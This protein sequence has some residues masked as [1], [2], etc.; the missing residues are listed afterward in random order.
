MSPLSRSHL[1][2]ALLAGAVLAL[3]PACLKP[4]P[5]IPFD[6]GRGYMVL[7]TASQR[8]LNDRY[9]HGYVPY[10][11]EVVSMTPGSAGWGWEFSAHLADDTGEDKER[12]VFRPTFQPSGQRVKFNVSV[13]TERDTE[14]YEVSAGVRQA[15]FLD[16]RIQPYFGVGTSVFYL[17]ERD[18]LEGTFVLTNPNNPAE[19]ATV[20]AVDESEREWNFGVYMR[21]GLAWR[22][23]GDQEG[24]RLGT[25]FTTDLRGM[26]GTYFSSVE[27]VFGF[28]FGR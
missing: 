20:T 6:H 9:V 24:K 1:S 7:A 27:F 11:L 16:S 17:R 18:D 22:L 2:R 3:L 28:G 10:G 4:G 8:W 21:T 13:P 26:L 23:T 15:F 19:T 12:K 5:R 14:F 25:F